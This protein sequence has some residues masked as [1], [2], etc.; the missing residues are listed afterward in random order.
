MNHGFALALVLSLAA[1]QGGRAQQ[2]VAGLSSRLGRSPAMLLAALGAAL[3]A[4]MAAS[5]AGAFVHAVLPS[6]VR[7]PVAIAAL[8]AAGI[9]LLLPLR[10]DTLREPTRSLGAIT[11]ALV[12]RQSV[13]APRLCLLALAILLGTPW[14]IAMGGAL[15]S[16]LALAMGWAVPRW[17]LRQ[18]L[19]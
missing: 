8:I 1:A 13:D 12:M 5:H 7:G 2:I 4:S 9:I 16:S 3:L 19:K 15:G 11:L 14:P 10:P 17:F 18:T 6:A